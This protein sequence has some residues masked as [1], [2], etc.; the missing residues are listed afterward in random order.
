MVAWSGGRATSQAQAKTAKS[1]R[2]TR[3]CFMKDPVKGTKRK[4]SK[5]GGVKKAKMNEAAQKRDAKRR[6]ERAKK[7][8]KHLASPSVQMRVG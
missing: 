5:A 1:N 6:K 4:G 2:K 8:K 7:S 3:G